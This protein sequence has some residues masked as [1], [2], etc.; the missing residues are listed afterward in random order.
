MSGAG[1]VEDLLVGV[2]W[3]AG[4]VAGDFGKEAML[5]RIPFGSADST[6]TIANFD[7][8]RKIRFERPSGYLRRYSSRSG[9]S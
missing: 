9:R 5:D 7:F 1:I 6:Y 4:P 2:Q 3:F 8:D